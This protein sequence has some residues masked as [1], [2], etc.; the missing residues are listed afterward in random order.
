MTNREH[1]IALLQSPE[2]EETILYF[3]HVFG[4]SHISGGECLKHANC[5]DCW[6]SWFESEVSTNGNA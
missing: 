1:L 3:N 2:D 5:F 4:C 6:K